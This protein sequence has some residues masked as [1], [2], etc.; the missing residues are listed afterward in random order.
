MIH[1]VFPYKEITPETVN[2]VNENKFIFHSVSKQP[3]LLA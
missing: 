3:L 1:F 2:D